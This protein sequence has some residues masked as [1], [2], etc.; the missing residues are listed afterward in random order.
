MNA[1]VCVCARLF[2]RFHDGIQALCNELEIS[3]KTAGTSPC[4][5]NPLLP[6]PL[7]DIP[8]ILALNILYAAGAIFDVLDTLNLKAIT[9]NQLYAGYKG[10]GAL[11]SGG[12]CMYVLSFI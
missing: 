12:I 7:P 5:P 8:E 2:V 9:Y 1:D 10:A 4:L 3:Q 6:S 11:F